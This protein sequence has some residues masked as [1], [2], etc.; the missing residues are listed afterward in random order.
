MILI[1]LN[2]SLIKNENSFLIKIFIKCSEV[3]LTINTKMV[4]PYEI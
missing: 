1:K 3:W 2:L 4:K